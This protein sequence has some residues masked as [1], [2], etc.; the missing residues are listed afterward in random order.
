MIVVIK[1]P[2]RILNSRTKGADGLRMSDS[3]ASREIGVGSKRN[4]T[5]YD[6]GIASCQAQMRRWC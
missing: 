2:H 6:L 5:R 3:G 4:I 1:V